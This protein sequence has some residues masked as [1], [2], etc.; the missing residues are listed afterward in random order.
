MRPDVVHLR[1]FYDSS[2]G[3]VAE[4]NI[5]AVL[6]QIWPTTKDESVL[7]FGFAA[8][9]LAKISESAFE[10]ICFMPER[11]GVLHW[12][13]VNK[14]ASALIAETLWPLPDATL[15][16]III[17]HGL[18]TSLNPSALL[19]EVWRV[20]KAG[21]KI[22]VVVPHRGGF[23]TKAEH[24]PFG[25]GHPYSKTQ[26]I[27]LMR[28]EL[29][30]PLQNKTTLPLPPSKSEV[31]LGLVRLMNKLKILRP[32]SQFLSKIMGGVLVLEATKQL[33]APRTVKTT[34]TAAQFIPMPAARAPL[35]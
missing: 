17:V 12:P 19:K 31:M 7:G 9:Y 20:L 16:K 14:N 22:I 10:A 15:D 25:H 3:H 23:W 11:Q 1:D 21:G 24:T 13:V 32:I 34:E 33:Y 27:A 28:A 35:G 4:E 18:E 2:L 29:F 26:L 5:S 6:K 8:P 30:V